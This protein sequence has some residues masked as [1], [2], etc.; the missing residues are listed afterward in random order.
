MCVD[1]GLC[2]VTLFTSRYIPT[3]RRNIIFPFSKFNTLKIVAA[4]FYET[5][6]LRVN[7]ASKH[8]KNIKTASKHSLIAN[9]IQRYFVV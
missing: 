4:N 5:L 9:S 2:V 1:V 3:F 7:T 6:Y 8:R